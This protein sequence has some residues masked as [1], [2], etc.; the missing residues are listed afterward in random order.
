LKRLFCIIVTALFIFGFKGRASCDAI[1]GSQQIDIIAEVPT[2]SPR[3][4]VTVS[5]ITADPNDPSGASDRW[6]RLGVLAMDFGKLDLDDREYTTTDGK[7]E[8]YYIFR[9]GTKGNN[10]ADSFYFAVDVGVLASPSLQWMVKHTPD[11][12]QGNQDNLNNNVNVVYAWVTQDQD[13]PNKTKDTVIE[14]RSFGSSFKI[15]QSN[16]SLRPANSWLRIYYGLG[17]G[18]KEGNSEGRSPDA[19]DVVPITLNKAPGIYRGR[20]T[21]TLVIK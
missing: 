5:K 21:L 1:A 15:L 3:L 14:R 19:P 2:I 16:D 13:N 18:V 4:E 7:T 6:E 17:S 9:T 20:V 12:I 8:R 11:S 10:F